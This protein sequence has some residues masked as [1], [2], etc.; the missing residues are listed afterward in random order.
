MKAES[1][2]SFLD[3]LVA[4]GSPMWALDP[5]LVSLTKIGVWVFFSFLPHTPILVS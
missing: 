5:I 3:V 4:L 1:A 2:F